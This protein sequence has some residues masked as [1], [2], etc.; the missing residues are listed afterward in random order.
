MQGT[1]E[2]LQQMRFFFS[3]FAAK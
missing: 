1:A 2:N 3:R